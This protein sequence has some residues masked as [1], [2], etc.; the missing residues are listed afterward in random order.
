MVSM[1][2][3]TICSRP[4][5][6]LGHEL[7]PLEHGDVLLHRGEAHRVPLGEPRDGVVA[8]HRA[9]DD[10]APGGVGECVEEPVGSL[11]VDRFY[12]HLVVD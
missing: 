11:G 7:G 9:H 2:L 1:L 10:V 6:L 12:N 8:P 4:L 3:R 5:T